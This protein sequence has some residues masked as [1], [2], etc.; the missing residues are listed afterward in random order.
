VSEVFFISDLHLGHKKIL[1]FSPQ[2]GGTDIV[3]HS[4][5][6]VHQWNNVVSKND[7]TWIL[8]DV[9]FDRDHMK[10]LKQM[11]GVKHL[12][13]GNHDLFGVDFYL[14]YFNK[15]HG[16]LKYKNHWLSHCPIHPNHL[17]GLINIHGHLHNNVVTELKSLSWD[18]LSYYPEVTKHYQIDKGYIN[19]SVEHLSGI[20]KTLKQLRDIHG[21]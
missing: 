3:S 9:C 2:R 12:I 14:H 6:L 13:L 7:V 16:F 4:E 15:V 20:P 10:Y 8:G 19:V 21:I 5:W 18:S 17:R 1:E 11:N